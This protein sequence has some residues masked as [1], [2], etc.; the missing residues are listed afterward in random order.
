MTGDKRDGTWSIT[1]DKDLRPAYYDQFHCLAAG[2]ELSC[3]IGWDI[4][5]NK[6]DYLSIKRQRASPELAERLDRALHRVRNNKYNG[7][8]YAE[9]DM[10]SG[11]CPLL[12]EDCLC[13][14]QAEKGP[15]ALPMICKKFPR[16]FIHSI[17]GYM[18]RSLSPACEGVLALLWELP[19]GIAFISDPLPKEDRRRLVVNDDAPLKRYFA[20]IRELCVDFLQD[21]RLPLPRRI[22]MM[23]MALRE[24]ADGTEDVPG[25]LSRSRAMADGLA[26]GGFPEEP[27]QEK[28]QA[29]FVTNAVQTL[30]MV[31][32]WD[33][34]LEHIREEILA[35]CGMS[36]TGEN[37]GVLKMAPYYAAR[38]RFTEK[39]GAR[40]YFFENLMVALLFHLNL[41][42][43]SSGETLWQS[44][45]NFCNVYAF[46]R[47]MAVTSC[48][49]GAA[50]DKAEL[51]RTM[52]YVS[53][54]L[55][56]NNVHRTILQEHLFQNESATLAHMAVLLSG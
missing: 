5:F 43:T 34:N 2:C 25:W 33:P 24:L 11:A 55:I 44:Y 32:T 15:E 45:V 39:F 36:I 31:E 29:L 14:L 47:F 54:S 46:Y 9:F 53:R 38:E 16:V 28:L 48:R 37:R 23:G 17:S 51:F 41:P 50:G 42:D 7:K 30:R 18:E 13:A 52:V 56:H 4:P 35:C 20:D 26:S 8:M 21:R 6:K 3:C 22:L 10:S 40:E 12:R 49:E 27:E 19:E 1:V